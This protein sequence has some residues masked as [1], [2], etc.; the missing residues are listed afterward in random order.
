MA[1][2]NK[3]LI[4]VLVYKKDMTTSPPDLPLLVAPLIGLE[5][6]RLAT[7]GDGITTLVAFHDCPLRCRYCLNSQ[8]LHA[9]G[10][11]KY[12]TPSQLLT[13]VVVDDLYFL[14]TGG[15]ITFGGGEP[16]LRGPFIESFCRIMPKQWRV[17]VETSLHVPQ[18]ALEKVAP[19]VHRFFIDVKDM[20]AGI[21]RAYTSADNTPVWRN[22]QWLA[23]KGLAERVV[24]RLPLIPQ[25]NTDADRDRSQQ[26]LESLGYRHFDRFEYRVEGVETL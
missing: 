23:E 19:Y 17:F 16:L 6:H 22:L 14:A 5:R 7:D 11:W 15:G 12:T 3:K 10:I 18:Q 8:C 24:I 21:Y 9:D 25:Y 20:N 2:S 4:F 26:R 13:E 1:I